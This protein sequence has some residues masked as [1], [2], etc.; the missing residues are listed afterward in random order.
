MVKVNKNI[1]NEEYR[2]M[3]IFCGPMPE[4]II[5]KFTK[6]RTTWVFPNSILAYYDYEYND[7]SESYLCFE[8]D[9]NR[10][11]FNKEF[12]EKDLYFKLRTFLRERYRTII[13]C[14]KYYTSISR[15]Q[16]WQITQNSLSDFI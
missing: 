14:Y 13:D 1:G 7:V 11:Q 16:L 3:I 12:K 10:C 8:F 2:K 9:F 5:N 4:K 6:P 15:Y